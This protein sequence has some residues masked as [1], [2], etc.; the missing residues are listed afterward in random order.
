MTKIWESVK[1]QLLI[2]DNLL[3]TMFLPFG[4][5]LLGLRPEKVPFGILLSV[6]RPVFSLWLVYPTDFLGLVARG[7]ILKKFRSP[8][9]EVLGICRIPSM[10]DEQAFAL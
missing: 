6:L 10:L 3:G 2:F 4:K 5:H 9:D 1:S 7:S 8:L